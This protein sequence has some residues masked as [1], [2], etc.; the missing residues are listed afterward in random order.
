MKFII[1]IFGILLL[2]AFVTTREFPGPNGERAFL[3]KCNGGSNDITDCYTEA[4][5][6]CGNK[7]YNVLNV[8]DG[9]NGAVVSGNMIIATNRRELTYTC[10]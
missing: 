8:I 3:T 10:K 1:A 4:A 2:S 6:Q 5:K 7:G 9:S